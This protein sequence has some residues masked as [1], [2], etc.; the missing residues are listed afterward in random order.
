MK[1]LEKFG[2]LVVALI[3]VYVAS[4]RYGPFGPMRHGYN[5]SLLVPNYFDN[6]FIRR[7]L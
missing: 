6:G 7:G 4:R 3:A 2:P 5:Q 1:S